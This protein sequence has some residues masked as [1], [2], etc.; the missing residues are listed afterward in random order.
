MSLSDI[1]INQLVEEKTRQFIQTAT[2]AELKRCALNTRSVEPVESEVTALLRAMLENDRQQAIDSITTDL[3]KKQIIDDEFEDKTDAIQAQTDSIRQAELIQQQQDNTKTIHEKEK[4]A[5]EIQK[6]LAATN[7]Q[8]QEL[9]DQISRGQIHVHVTPSLHNSI[10][11]VA[12]HH[13]H[14]MPPVT[15][16]VH[17][18]HNN[19]YLAQLRGQRMALKST[20]SKQLAVL[21]LL[22][23]ACDILKARNGGIWQELQLTIPR[24]ARE[25]AERARTRS[26]RNTAREENSLD[27]NRLLSAQAILTRST[28]ITQAHEKLLERMRDLQNYLETHSY[29]L[30]RQQ[31]ERELS[32]GTNPSLNG[33]DRAALGQVRHYIN[34]YLEAKGREYASRTELNRLHNALQT[35]T[36]SLREKENEVADLDQSNPRLSLDSATQETLI[37]T[38]TS[39]IVSHHSMRGKL[40]LGGSI[41]LGVTVGG[42]IAAGLTIFFAAVSVSLFPVLFVPA[43]VAF[44]L[45]ASLL[46]GAM[47]MIW[48]ERRDRH[49]IT[50]CKDRI[51]GNTEQIENQNRRLASLRETE[52]P[53][54]NGRIGVSRQAIDN[55]RSDI[56]THE[57]EAAGHMNKA[58]SVE[59][60]YASSSMS[61]VFSAS[62][63]APSAPP[64]EQPEFEEED[65][66]SMDSPVYP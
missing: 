3:Y 9:D 32:Y 40:F 13:T 65:T 48:K 27:H 12:N 53:D 57:N 56:A 34:E 58:K 20:Q 31:L 45:A 30:F 46:I 11:H 21:H 39:A 43:M 66:S 15:P 50:L 25:R 19:S 26:F 18:H 55:V 60:I 5:A 17:V 8:I 16:V 44:L 52:I 7:A 62:S 41:S 23:T 28:R 42:A 38:L 14:A 24:K 54:L 10:Q 1:I 37:N 59:P 36:R 6:E 33:G 29:S 64:L 35:Q 51:T 4:E 63:C 61:T 49:Q 47:V 2:F 22:N